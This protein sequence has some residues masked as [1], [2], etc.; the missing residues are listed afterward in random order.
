M[1]IQDILLTLQQFWIE[2]GCTLLHP[3][4]TEVGAATLHPVTMSKS[5]GQKPWKIAYLQP[6][7]RPG[8][9]RYAQNPNR[10]QYYYQFQ[11]LIKPS[12]SDIQDLCLKSIKEL[13]IDNKN[14][15]IRF[16][17]NDW[18]NVTLGA[19][20]VGWEVWCDGMEIIQFTYM[21]QV[22]GIQCSLIP[23]E[24][25]YGIERVAM[26]IQNKNSVWDLSWSKKMNYREIYQDQE[27]EF[28]FFNFE[29]E[30]TSIL[31]KHFSDFEKM[32]IDL[33]NKNLVY[34]SYS[35]CLKA[36]HTFNILD[37]RN[38]FSVTERENYVS[39]IRDLS[40]S[41]CDKFLKK[42]G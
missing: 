10:M 38:I 9:G 5:L 12:P 16:L 2:Q 22:G 13:G 24:I 31:L 4:D 30:N 19:C 6:C 21:Q 3:I 35:Y 41:C 37:S 33:L 42:Y 34:P 17:H 18:E 7:R 1:F 14:H 8:D 40:K 29:G 27:I 23:A 25:T 15:D 28:C 20:G 36:S 26:Y 32:S 39:R 11:V